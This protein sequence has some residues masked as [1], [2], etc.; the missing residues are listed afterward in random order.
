MADYYTNVSMELALPSKEAVDYAIDLAQAMD[1]CA[2]A[3]TPK[4]DVPEGWQENIED[5]NWT[6]DIKKEGD[7]SI[8]IHSECGCIDEIIKL[9]QHLMQKFDMTEPVSFEWSNDCSKPRVDA[10]GGGAAYI[11][12]TE[13]RTFNTSQWLRAQGVGV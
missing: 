1:D 9:I 6:F 8:W 13:V 12:A 11:T 10:Y 5:E 2:R 4:T 7:R 3:I